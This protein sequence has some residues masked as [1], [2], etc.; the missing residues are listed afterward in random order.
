V[1]ALPKKVNER[2]KYMAPM[3]HLSFAR[4]DETRTF[5]KGKVDLA[6][7][8]PGHDA[9]VL[10]NLPVVAIDI[11]GLVDYAKPL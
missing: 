11:D 3:Q 1:T 9:W 8:P 5:E 2:N 10:G 7:I 4:S 6:L